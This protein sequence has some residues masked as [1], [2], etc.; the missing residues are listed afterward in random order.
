MTFAPQAQPTTFLVNSDNHTAVVKIE[1]PDPIPVMFP[2]MIEDP[3][4]FSGY[5]FDTGRNTCDPNT[6]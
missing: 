4:S 6:G 2:S 5:S 1:P 3:T